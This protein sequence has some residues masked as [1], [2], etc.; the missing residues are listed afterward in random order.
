MRPPHLKT[1]DLL[2]VLFDKML[3]LLDAVDWLFEE[4]KGQL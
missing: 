2:K 1:T 3:K 4:E